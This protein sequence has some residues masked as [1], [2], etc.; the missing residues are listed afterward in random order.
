MNPGNGAIPVQ[1]VPVVY[2]PAQQSSPQVLAAQR[3]AASTKKGLSEQKLGLIMVVPAIVMMLVVAAWPVF[4]A[5]RLSL[6]KYNIKTPDDTTFVGLSNYTRVL[7]SGHWWEAVGTTMYFTIASVSIEFLLG[8]GM[9]LVMNRALGAWTGAVRVAILI[10]WAT[11]TVVTALAWKWLFTPET[12]FGFMNG[13]MSIFAGEGSC[14]LCGRFTS[15]A[16]MVMA[17]VWKTAPFIALLLLAGLQSI[18]GEMYEAADV[19][20]ASPWTKFKSITLPCLKPAILVAL[21][22]RTL[23]AVRM[24]DLGYVMTS[25]ANKTESV[26]MLAYDHLI[27]RLNIGLGSAMSVLIF[28]MVIAIALFFSKVLGAN[29]DQTAKAH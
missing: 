18:D 9:A 28:L 8:L 29:S 4:Q 14:M 15:I 16:T 7:S 24:F 19:D 10:P 12:T 21:L 26:S 27:R 11:I 17:D 6:Y 5:I 25:G 1:V 23:D 13:V 22:F 2:V 20:G 3:R